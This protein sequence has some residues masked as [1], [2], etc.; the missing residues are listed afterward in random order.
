MLEGIKRIKGK[1]DCWFLIIKD[2]LCKIIII[3]LVV[4]NIDFEVSLFLVLF[5]LV[6][7]VF[8]ELMNLFIV[9]IINC[10]ILFFYMILSLLV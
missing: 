4:C 7:Y 5:F 2:L 6:Y 3:M 10:I 1:K 9:M 8:L